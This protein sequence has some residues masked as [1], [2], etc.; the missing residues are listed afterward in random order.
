MATQDNEHRRRPPPINIPPLPL[1]QAAPTADT[2]ATVS[3]PWQNTRSQPHRRSVKDAPNTTQQGPRSSGN[4]PLTSPLEQGISRPPHTGSSKSRTSAMTTLSSLVDH[5]RTSPRKSESSTAANSQRGSTAQS[6]Y[7]S[8]TQHNTTTTQAQLEVFEEKT[9]RGRIESRSERNFF[10]LTGQV[11]PTPTDG[12]NNEDDVYIRTE[13]FRNQCRAASEER[14]PHRDEPTK[15]P[16]KKLFSNIRN[17]FAKTANSVAATAAM[18]SKAAQ[19]LGTSARRRHVVQPRPIKSAQSTGT[20]TKIRRSG[21]A[22]SLPPKVV[23]SED[24]SRRHHRRGS[25]QRQ[26]DAENT[27]PV[28]QV[29]CSFETTVPPTPPA[30]D[31]PPESRSM[32]APSS[33][34]RRAA[35]AQDLRESYDTYL[36]KGMKLRFPAFALSPSPSC[37][38]NEQRAGGTSPTKFRPYTAEDYSKLIEDCEYPL[39]P[40]KS[41]EA[42]QL[43][44]PELWKALSHEGKRTSRFLSPLPPRFYSPSNRSVRL[45]A[46]GESPSKN[47]DTSRLL[48]SIPPKSNLLQLRE[49]SKNGSIEMMFQGDATDIDPQSATAELATGSHQ[50]QLSPAPVDEEKLASHVQQDSCATEQREHSPIKYDR[51]GGP[52]HD[53]P[54]SRLTDMLRGVNLRGGAYEVDFEPKCPSA[55]PSPLHKMQMHHTPL[56]PDLRHCVPFSPPVMPPTPK[57]IDDHFFMT[58]E[59]LDVVGKTT[60]DLLEGLNRQQLDTMTLKHD[61]LM[62]TIETKAEDIRSQVNTVNEKADRAAERQNNIQNDLEKI[63]SLVK[64]EVSSAFAMQEKRTS[65][66]EAQI[67]ELRATVMDLLKLLEQKCKDSRV[68]VQPAS[69]SLPG[70]TSAPPGLGPLPLHRSQPSLTGYYG[71]T[72]DFGR[73]NAPPMPQEGLLTPTDAPGDARAGYSSDYG[74]QHWARP[75]YSNRNSRNPYSA[76]TNPYHFANGGGYSVGYSGGHYGSNFGPNSPDQYNGFNHNASK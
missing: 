22:K 13:D 6:R 67:K 32:H 63:L 8:R 9:S 31:T 19:V 24:Y 36:D 54:S 15:S 64:T 43:A 75:A 56:P 18:P 35:P 37:M 10:K 17:P 58:N 44:V 55:V 34:L 70:H 59:H 11:P 27:P 52:Q 72:P 57:H 71:N 3:Q 33:P 62:A 69:E 76:G 38:N 46:E 21:T 53:Q 30:K 5:A 66:M 47:S 61:R 51:P 40:S 20:P 29:N 4:T 7:S 23:D 50:E 41:I 39:S 60:W 45:F 12:T 16:K 49:D 2:S 26:R 14:H 48:F 74:S 68:N 28:P 42:L 65:Q 25:T 1:P 73:E